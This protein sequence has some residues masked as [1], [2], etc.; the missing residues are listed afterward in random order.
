MMVDVIVSDLVPLRERGNFIAMVLTVYGLSTSVGPF[1]GGIIVQNTSWSWIFCLNLPIGGVA[2]VFLFLFLH[3][4]YK[5]DLTLM[6]RLKR[7]DYNGNT[8]VVASTVSV[9]LALT[10]AGSRYLWSS[11]P[12]LVPLILGICGL[13]FFMA[14]ENSNFCPH[15]VTPPQIFG[16]RTSAIVF[17]NTF[18]FTILLY[19]VLFFRF[20]SRQFSDP[21][22]PEPECNSSRPLSLQFLAPPSP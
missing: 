5:R 15:P 9:L 1:L 3:V 4:N 12:T 20:I 11:W 22:P 8:I 16:N 17:V 14:F 18:L 10:N 7:I 19:W 6:E 2:L 13:F 21:L